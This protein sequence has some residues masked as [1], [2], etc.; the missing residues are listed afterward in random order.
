MSAQPLGIARE[1]LARAEHFA[2]LF[3]A[4]A[5]AILGRKPVYEAVAAVE[6]TVDCRTGERS[7][8]KPQPVA[9]P[10]KIEAQPKPKKHIAVDH[11]YRYMPSIAWIMGERQRVM[12]K[13]NAPQ[14][15]ARD[16]CGRKYVKLEHSYASAIATICAECWGIDR[17]RVMMPGRERRCVRPR[18]AAFKLLYE[19]SGVSYVQIGKYFG[20]D[21]TT[22][23]HG[24]QK[25]TDLIL[26]DLNFRQR[27]EQASELLDKAIRGEPA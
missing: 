8:Y 21:H 17:T 20:R 1:A 15:I 26:T 19:R 5:R 23:M 13:L 14:I 12:D 10:I 9:K 24:H 6:I 7:I 16:S 18:Q 27:Y 25:A 4:K 3:P 11:R 22:V 2:R